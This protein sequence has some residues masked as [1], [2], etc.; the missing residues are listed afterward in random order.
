MSFYLQCE[1]GREVLLSPFLEIEA[2]KSSVTYGCSDRIGGVA[3]HGPNLNHCLTDFISKGG[4]FQGCSGGNLGGLIRDAR[5][6]C[7]GTAGLAQPSC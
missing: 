3:F 1:L 4:C 5:S 7:L 6:S 2:Q